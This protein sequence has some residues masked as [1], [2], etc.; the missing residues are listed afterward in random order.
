MAPARKHFYKN[1][2]FCPFHSITTAS[3]CQGKTVC[4]PRCSSLIHL[5]AF[6]R[7]KLPVSKAGKVLDSFCAILLF[8]FQRI[9]PSKKAA[10][11]NMPLLKSILFRV[12][13]MQRSNSS[14]C[15]QRNYFSIG[16]WS[17]TAN[18]HKIYFSFTGI[19][20]R[21]KLVLFFFCDL[22]FTVLD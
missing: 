13:F 15:A 18:I 2:L 14:P 12:V 3:F 20:D 17:K 4:Q 11:K 16:V 1:S 8:L 21:I 19:D 10:R 9:F 22:R 6:S 7:K 5:I